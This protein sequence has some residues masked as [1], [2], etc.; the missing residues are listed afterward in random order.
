MY[1]INKYKINSKNDIKFHFNIYNKLLKKDNYDKIY[2]FLNKDD[3]YEKYYN[4][5]VD[6]ENKD[7]NDMSNL[8]IYGP[9]GSGKKTLI[10]ILLKDIYGY[11]PKLQQE[12]YY[13][14]Y[15]GDEKEIE[16]L[17]S[18]NHI[19]INPYNSALDKIIIQE[20][21]L[22]NINVSL[23][24]TFNQKN[25][26][27]II[28]INNANNLSYNTQTSLRYIIEKYNK[29][30]KFILCA[31]SINKFIEPILSRCLM[32]QVPRP[33]KI[34][35]LNYLKMIVNEQ[36]INIEDDIIKKII[37]SSNRN[38]RESIWKIEIYNNKKSCKISNINYNNLKY[39]KVMKLIYENKKC[40]LQTF[41]NLR[42]ILYLIYSLNY[43]LDNFL[44][45][46]TQFIINM[47]NGDN[48]N[49]ISNII[50]HILKANIRI[51][52]CK[53]SV[54]HLETMTLKIIKEL[55]I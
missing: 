10:N 15:N 40:D 41:K 7:Y 14:N 53:K 6:H 32:I 13:I 23:I 12:I 43:N 4:K 8:I 30:C 20:I 35:L 24:K 21:I 16:I 51:N 1:L 49:K 28:L 22:K 48:K 9:K 50:D 26:F 44:T 31:D 37:K 52:T 17:Q 5:L 46:L 47:L 18:I 19:I 33:D 54:L 42:E 36:K 29:T 3:N 34:E 55:C 25:K 45:G 39:N 2:D 11:L 38:I 27:R